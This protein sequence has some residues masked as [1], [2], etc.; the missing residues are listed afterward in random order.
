[1]ERRGD[2]KDVSEGSLNSSAGTQPC[3]KASCHT[4]HTI[5]EYTSLELVIVAL[6]QRKKADNPETC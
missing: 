6:C 3:E 4:L 2:R 5:E 1:M